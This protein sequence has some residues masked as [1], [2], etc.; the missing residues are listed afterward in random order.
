MLIDETQQQQLVERARAAAHAARQRGDLSRAEM[1]QQGVWE[2]YHPYQMTLTGDGIGIGDV[3]DTR[4]NASILAHIGLERVA[5]HM[6]LIASQ[7]HLGK[8][9]FLSGPTG[10]GKTSLAVIAFR[11]YMQAAPAGRT[12]YFVRWPA[13]LARLCGGPWDEGTTLALHLSKATGLLVIDDLASAALNGT[14]NR[15]RLEYAETLILNRYDKGMPT[16]F[17][18]NLNLER[19]GSQLGQ[20]IASRL[21]ETAVEYYI[22]G[23]DLRRAQ[24]A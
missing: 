17:T 24:R 22:G 21:S 9:V 1:V 15:R 13:F 18:S 20:R 4:D 12:S 8:S 19:I 16:L 23:D 2:P 11:M 3:W 7:L 5:E 14:E 6:R 10:T